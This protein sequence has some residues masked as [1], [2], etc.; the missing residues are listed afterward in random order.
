MD[1]LVVLVD[2]QEK[3]LKGVTKFVVVGFWE[4][5]V[6]LCGLHNC[7]GRLWGLDLEGD[8]C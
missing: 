5:K 3:F 6:D 8:F 1:L 2:V 4:E 7:W